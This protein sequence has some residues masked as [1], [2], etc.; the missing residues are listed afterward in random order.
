MEAKRTYQ[1]REIAT[2]LIVAEFDNFCDMYFFFGEKE[3]DVSES[4]G[5]GYKA[6]HEKVCK[7]YKAY[8]TIE[9]EM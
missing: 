8:E 1:V 3:H 9:I 2:G 7:I 6:A 5:L 4:E